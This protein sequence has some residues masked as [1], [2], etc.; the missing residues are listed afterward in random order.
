MILLA[1]NSYLLGPYAGH[2]GDAGMLIHSAAVGMQ[3]HTSMLI[4]AAGIAILIHTAD[5]DM[6]SVTADYLLTH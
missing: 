2:T 6:L 5:P 3:I 1:H 4:Y